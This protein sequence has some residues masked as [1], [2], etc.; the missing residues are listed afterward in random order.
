ME[1][2]DL[3]IFNLSPMAMWIQ[4]F[5]EIKKIFQQWVDSGITDLEHYLLEDPDRLNPC[6]AVIKT[7]EVNQST[8]NLYEANDLE[9]IL[10]SF[11]YLHAEKISVEKVKFFMAL[12]NRADQYVCPS[13][14]YTSKGKK[15]DIQLRASFM[16]GFEDTWERLLLT[17]ENV[18]D[19][20]EARRFAESIVKFS[21]SA[22]IVKDYS[23][24]KLKFDHL[25][26]KQVVDLETYIKVHPEFVYEC[27]DAI[28][29]LGINKTCLDLF[30][31]QDHIQ[32]HQH[33]SHIF[34]DYG[35]PTY[36]NQLIGLWNGQ[37]LQK[38]E[39]HYYTSSQKTL[40]L[41]EQFTVFPDHIDTW[42]VIQIALTDITEQKVMENHLKFLG[43]HDMLTELFNRAFFNAEIEKLS[44]NKTH[45][46]SCIYLD[47]NGLKEINDTY[48][49]SEGDFI[50]QRFGQILKIA[51]HKTAFSASR[52]GGDEFVILMP[53]ATPNQVDK[54][55]NDV[56]NALK[57]DQIKYQERAIHVA[58]GHA[59][60]RQNENINELLKRA[61]LLMYTNKKNF[62]ALNHFQ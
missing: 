51:I 20:Q 34:F 24:I 10:Q 39:C 25:R 26:S 40:H 45:P 58:I 3:T 50:L 60:S 56:M 7:I 2:L 49:H 11:K 32:F 27:F 37:F 1:E 31:T 44:Q 57:I 6:L 47:I 15:I 55:I 36:K 42:S 30:E 13:A 9:D 4:D 54:L 12:W 5:S 28:H 33:M 48:G 16:P 53:E 21:P 52:I 14:N 23:Q 29:L 22:L 38:R 62:Y 46:I 17:T 35:N 61:D 19:I 18:T 43:Q 59:S 8:L 41:L